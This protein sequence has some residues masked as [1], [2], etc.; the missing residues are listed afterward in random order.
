MIR[1][2]IEQVLDYEKRTGERVKRERWFTLW[3][4]KR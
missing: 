3:W 1:A 2:L 4:K